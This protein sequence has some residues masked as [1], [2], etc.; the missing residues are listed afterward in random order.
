M[1]SE[2]ISGPI[3]AFTLRRQTEALREELFSAVCRVAE[4]CAFSGGPYTA[5][6]EKDF[7]AFLGAGRFLGVSNGSDALL[8]ALLAMGIGPGDEVIVPANTFIA[9][10]FS[11]LRAGAVPIFADCDPCLWEIDPSSVKKK[12]TAR[13]RAVIGVHLYGPAF[14]LVEIS[15]LASS[16][17]IRLIEDCAQSHGTLYHGTCVGIAADAGCFSF[18]PSKNLGAWG[19]AGGLCLSSPELHEK[20]TRIRNQGSE[21][22][23]HHTETGCNMRMD[24]IQ[25][26]VLS[27]KLKHLAAWNAARARIMEI[28][29]AEIPGQ[30]IRFQSV[31]PDTVPAWHL[32][33][34]CVDDRS[35]FL[36]HMEDCGITCG[37][38]YPVPCHLQ[39]AVASLGGRPGDFPNAEYLSEHCVSL[40]L[41]PEMTDTEIGRVVDACRSY[42]SPS[43][44]L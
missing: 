15:R 17:G 35:R 32:A 28:Y 2:T 13:T 12:I 10:V 18:Y 37:M 5:A 1:R 22:K 44:A 16:A 25:G 42:C 23:Y 39:P 36:R 9:T 11:V 21:S 14:P 6:F 7:A 38:H 4:D 26:A 24:G 41:F 33:V 19:E 34:I 30:C 40:P 20:A 27:V 43:S 8:L 31:L 3:P 29:H